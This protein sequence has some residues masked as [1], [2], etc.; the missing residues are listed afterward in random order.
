MS[1]VF[2]YLIINFKVSMSK[3]IRKAGIF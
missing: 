2:W 3:L 1:N